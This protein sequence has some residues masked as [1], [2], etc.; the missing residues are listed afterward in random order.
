M[1]LAE[2][3]LQVPAQFEVVRYILRIGGANSPA[4][5]QVSDAFKDRAHPSYRAC[6]AQVEH[7]MARRRAQEKL[8]WRIE[9][10]LH[11]EC[12]QRPDELPVDGGDIEER[13]LFAELRQGLQAPVNRRYP[14]EVALDAI[15]E[16]QRG[17]PDDACL[18][19]AKMVYTDPDSNRRYESLAEHGRG[20][21]GQSRTD[22]C[23][24]PLVE[25]VHDPCQSGGSGLPGS[26]RLGR[27][28]AQD[29]G[30]AR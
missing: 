11:Y 17:E 3:G 29:R 22:P 12:A 9:R 7:L 2:D 13:A 4:Y 26:R 10:C 20:D 24:A 21:P 6:V 23:P 8:S 30:L 18:L 27:S 19:Q 25:S 14:I 16:M 1:Q 15:H 5:P 28:Q